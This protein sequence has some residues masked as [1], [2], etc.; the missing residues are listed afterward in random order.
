VRAYHT[1]ATSR[2]ANDPDYSMKLSDERFA[3]VMAR[4]GSRI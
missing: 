2:P 4:I 1:N 3:G